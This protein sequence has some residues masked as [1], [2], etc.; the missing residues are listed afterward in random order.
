MANCE[1]HLES[2][3]IDEETTVISNPE[4]LANFSK[5]KT[6][7]SKKSKYQN[8]WV[9]HSEETKE[10]IDTF[11]PPENEYFTRPDILNKVW[12]P[13][14]LFF[15]FFTT[16]MLQFICE[17][18]NQY[19]AQ[20]GATNWDLLTPAELKCFIGIIMLTSYV[21]LPSTRMYWEEALDVGQQII[22]NAMPRNR[23]QA[24]LRYIHFTDNATIDPNDKCG[25][26]RPLLD[27]LRANC[28]LS[29]NISKHMNID[30]S[31][32]PYYGKFGN[33]LKQHMVKKPIRFG[34]KVY[35]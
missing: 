24:I 25:K 18:T 5:K 23:F 30:E 17:M 1:L 11:E 32:I 15:L 31:M 9:K 29:A 13:L 14:E 4:E 35:A 34:Y 21:R 6:P 7:V 2:N 26:V 22:Q 3:D 16:E 27:M 33:A 8:S 28:K 19:A 10:T 20:S 12:T